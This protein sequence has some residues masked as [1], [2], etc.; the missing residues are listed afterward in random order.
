MD[1]IGNK[2]MI[3]N[4]NQLIDIA[5]QIEISDP[6]DW[7]MLHI[8]EKDAYKLIASDVLENYSKADKEYRELILLATVVKLTVENFAVN[9]KLLQSKSCD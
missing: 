3:D 5:E 9:L 8:N 6:I 4:L 1:Q 2:L 7:G